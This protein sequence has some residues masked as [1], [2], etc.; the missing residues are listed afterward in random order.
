MTLQVTRSRASCGTAAARP[1][2][3]RGS[4]FGLHGAGA[5]SPFRA[6]ER[7]YM[8]DSCLLQKMR[9]SCSACAD[10]P[11]ALQKHKQRVT[12]NN[13]AF[14]PTQVTPGHDAERQLTREK[15]LHTHSACLSTAARFHSAEK[16]APLQCAK[17]KQVTLRRFLSSGLSGF[18]QVVLNASFDD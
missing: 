13:P 7:A 10:W 8:A 16:H 17:R 14:P 9:V 1:P 6:A 3:P 18:R 12:L 4:W 2:P 11:R 5:S 15:H